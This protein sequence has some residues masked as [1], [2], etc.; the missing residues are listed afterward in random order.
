MALIQAASGVALAV[1]AQAQ[2]TGPAKIIVPAQMGSPDYRIAMAL[3]P[4]LSRELG[5]PVIVDAHGVNGAASF[6]ASARDGH[7]I[8]VARDTVLTR[9]PHSS[10]ASALREADLGTI[11]VVGE[12]VLV[13][14]CNAESGIRSSAD[15]RAKRN[16]G[17]LRLGVLDDPTHTAY[18]F[19]LMRDEPSRFQAAAYGGIESLGDAVLGKTIDCALLPV[20][21]AAPK[22]RR[23]ALTAVAVST[24]G[25]AP[26]LPGVPT[27]GAEL[28]VRM[29][30]DA[31]LLATQPGLPKAANEAVAAATARALKDAELRRL[32][33]SEGFVATPMTEVESKAL[34]RRRHADWGER[35]KVR[36]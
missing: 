5:V 7:A 25:K 9:D 19:E 23:G 18:A 32:L 27:L 6:A 21:W 30:M 22:I 17:K 1:A 31:Y 14:A 20:N 4:A 3:A 2:G 36:R 12:E 33:E 15:W 34:L 16:P 10:P 26:Q 8:F 28:G 24:S 13:L 35:L 11:T 29:T